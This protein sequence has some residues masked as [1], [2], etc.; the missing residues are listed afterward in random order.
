[1]TSIKIT[2]LKSLIGAIKASPSKSYS[3]RAFI[4]A[5]L[6]DGVSVIKNPLTSGDV[7]IT[8]EIL[9]LLGVRILEES[10][11]TY[12]VEKKSDSFDSYKQIID[13]KNSGTSIRIFSALSLLVKDGLTFTGEFL[14]RNRPIRPLLESLKYLGGDYSLEMDQLQVKRISN[15][16]DIVK[17]QGDISSQ[18]ITALLF[19]S[20]YLKCDYK[21]GIEIELTTP[22]VSHPYIEI[23][24]DVLSSFG[25]HVL[26]DLDNE[27]KG[28][29]YIP[30][31]QKYRPQVYEIPGDFSSAA[32]I[33][34]AAALAPQDS[35]VIINN[36]NTKN[37]QGD[38]KIIEILQKMGANIQ[39]NQKQNQVAI[40]GN[41]TKY[42]L[43]GI[44]IDCIEIPDLFPLLCVIGAFA[45]GKTTLF[46]ASNLRRKESDRI[47]VMVRELTKMGVKID[48]EEDKITVYH[49][50]VNGSEIDHENDHRIAM[51]CVIAAIYSTNHS[52]MQNIEIINDS[53]P[54]FIEDLLNLGANIEIIK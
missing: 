16:C 28:K 44:D 22:L 41:I 15:K 18:F 45:E 52:T 48:E 14:K 30:C 25:I 21:D 17:I 26:E 19:I 10:K 12:I 51:A 42:H 1:M 24:M 49:S 38:K 5:S 23:T 47:S 6:A 36:L 3:H 32:F 46:N 39:I 40:K 31:G 4:A 29:Y 20:T 33:I 9:K 37:P 43:Y 54:N 8:I 34:A 13:C 50:S 2:P 11:H 7:K 35:T 53:Y 27:K